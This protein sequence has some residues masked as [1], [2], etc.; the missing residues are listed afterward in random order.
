MFINNT[1]NCEM[2][3][4]MSIIKSILN[5]FDDV[6]YEYQNQTLIPKI[7]SDQIWIAGYFGQPLTDP[8]FTVF[9]SDFLFT[10]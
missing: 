1:T 6:Q 2:L 8:Y 10:P 7:L 9:S 3:Q 4:Q 5:V